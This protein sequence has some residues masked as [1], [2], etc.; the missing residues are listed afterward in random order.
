[1]TLQEVNKQVN[2]VS[3]VHEFSDENVNLSLEY[4]LLSRTIPVYMESI[5]SYTR[6]PRLRYVV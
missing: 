5:C 6:W 1:M 2:F 4:Y 3:A